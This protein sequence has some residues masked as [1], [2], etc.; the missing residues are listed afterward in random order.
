MYLVPLNDGLG[1]SDDGAEELDGVA[2]LSHVAVEIVGR[3]FGGTCK[4]DEEESNTNCLCLVV[5]R[6]SEERE[7]CVNLSA[8]SHCVSVIALAR[9]SKE[10]LG[11][12]TQ[13]DTWASYK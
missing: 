6:A 3:R 10:R 8:I 12:G 11:V 2:L 1:V 9:V 13:T 4:E 5:R 7:E